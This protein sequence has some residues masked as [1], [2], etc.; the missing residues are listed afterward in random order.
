[1]VGTFK[2]ES[3]VFFGVASGE[4][5]EA[6]AELAAA[7]AANEAAWAQMTRARTHEER[8]TAE[9]AILRTVKRLRAAKRNHK[10]TD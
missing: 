7:Q 9:S 8:E 5:G 10:K 6:A 4:T 2:N 1:M 3:W